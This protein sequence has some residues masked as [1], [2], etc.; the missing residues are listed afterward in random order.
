MED[1]HKNTPMA[2]TEED[3][4]EYSNATRCHICGD[5]LNGDKG[6]TVRDHDHANGKFRGAA[7]NTCNLAEGK[8]NVKNF[9]IPVFFHNLKNYD[10]HIVITNVGE[11]TS[12]IDVIALNSEK[13]ISLSDEFVELSFASMGSLFI[14]IFPLYCRRF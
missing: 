3:E 10:G 7:H 14:E 5:D 4:T 13:Y 9:K 8:R 6:D 1:I 11:F 12:K 2:M